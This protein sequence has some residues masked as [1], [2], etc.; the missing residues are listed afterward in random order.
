MAAGADTG[1]LQDQLLS[2]LAHVQR[3]TRVPGI[4]AAI[5]IDG[6]CTAAQI[7][8][9]ANDRPD[10]VTADTEFH[11]GCITKLFLAIA[12]LEL[13]R[14]GQLDLESPIQAYLPELRGTVH[15][16][17][18][19]LSHLLSHTS[20]YRGIDIYQPG[21]L[22]MDWNALVDYLR[23]A[24]RHFRPGTV[25]SYE[26]SEAVITGAIIERVTGIPPMAHIDEI[27]FAPLGITARE[28]DLAGRDSGSQ[29]GQHMPDP[30][31]RGYRQVTFAELAARTGTLSTP[32]W[33]A[34]FSRHTVSLDSLLAIAGDLMG[35]TMS[36]A[37]P[38]PTAKLAAST[39]SQ[40]Q[41]P[42][43]A[44][45]A[46]VSG[47]LA[48]LMPVSFSLGASQWRDGF[49]GI[50]GSTYGQCQGVRFDARTGTAVAVGINVL[51]PHLRDLVISRI[52]ESVAGLPVPISAGSW[53]ELELP[54]L[55]GDY[56][57]P[58]QNRVRITWADDCL[59]LVIA[60]GS[61]ALKLYAEIHRKSDNALMLKAQSP[62]LSIGF[63]READNDNVGL[64]VG[65]HAYKRIAANG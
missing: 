49:Q 50:G 38:D 21:T 44:L 40:L 24:P 10:P 6:T 7:G 1:S 23:S 46:M 34:A 35:G 65:N 9:L 62:H 61:T 3:A 45:P 57:G 32:M 47:P 5:R 30:A 54:E 27:L 14:A 58:G 64:M 11:L 63:F 20:G 12:V 28:L 53:T 18:I 43:V 42:V 25:F 16:E 60:S 31:T 33:D 52:C 4:G 48:E 17:S 8:V 2:F 26:H 51:Q 19:N 37:T 59:A 15:G 13:A 29:A 55:T 39:L 36:M 41:R 22:A 56:Y